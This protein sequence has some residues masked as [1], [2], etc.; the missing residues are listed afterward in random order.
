MGHDKMIVNGMTPLTQ[1]FV[2]L[3]TSI[4]IL[5]TQIKAVPDQNLE[6]AANNLQDILKVEFNKMP[7]TQKNKAKE[8]L[9]Q[10]GIN[11]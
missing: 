9:S 10:K 7:D 6:L 8:V 11:L 5:K 2:N 4:N 3:F 1:V